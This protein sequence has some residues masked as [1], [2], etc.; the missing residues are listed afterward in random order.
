MMSC[1]IST[2]TDTLVIAMLFDAPQGPAVVIVAV[3][4]NMIVSAAILVFE[5]ERPRRRSRRR[6]RTAAMTCW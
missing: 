4:A 6:H 1:N 3:I 2:Y 5:S